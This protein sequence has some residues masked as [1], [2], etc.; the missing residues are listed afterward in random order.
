LPLHRKDSETL[1]VSLRRA[2]SPTQSRTS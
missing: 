2:Q 1:P